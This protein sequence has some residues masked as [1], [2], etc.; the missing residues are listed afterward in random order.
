M[1]LCQNITI[2]RFWVTIMWLMDHNRLRFILPKNM[3]L[4]DKF[5]IGM[6]NKLLLIHILVIFLLPIVQVAL[7][8][9]LHYDEYPL[10]NFGVS[11]N[12]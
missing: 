3:A 9:F 10:E 7:E 11:K 5:F 12:L 2:Q 4:L 6:F 8:K 1:K